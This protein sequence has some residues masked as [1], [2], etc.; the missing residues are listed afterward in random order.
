MGFLAD[1]YARDAAE[2]RKERRIRLLAERGDCIEHLEV[3]HLGLQ[4]HRVN[5]SSPSSAVQRLL[6]MFCICGDRIGES[7]FIVA[8]GSGNHCHLPCWDLVAEGHDP[9]VPQGELF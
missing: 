6:D 2:F 1:N 5:A 8:P 9:I 3:H 4:V 7:L